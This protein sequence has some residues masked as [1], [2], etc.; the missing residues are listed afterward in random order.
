[1]CRGELETDRV[2][3]ET[4]RF[5]SP[6]QLV[7]RTAKRDCTL[8]GVE[9]AEGDAVGAC[10]GAA[11][12]DPAEFSSPDVFDPTRDLRRHISFSHG[13]HY[14]LGAPFAR[15]EADLVLRCLMS[16]YAALENLGGAERIPST[17]VRGFLKLPLALHVK[18]H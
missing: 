11:N 10:L 6:I 1:L 5:E 9:F 4:L 17:L 8:N 15:A 14:C 16:R 3:E 2:I 13:I 7:S 12:R 18:V